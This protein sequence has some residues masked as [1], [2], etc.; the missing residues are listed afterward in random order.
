MSLYK[1]RK[2]SGLIETF[3]ESKIKEAVKKAIIASS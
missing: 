3:E 2:R 1:I